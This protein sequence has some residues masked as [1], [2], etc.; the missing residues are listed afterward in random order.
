[1]IIL[2]IAFQDLSQMPF[3]QHDHV[4]QA[5]APDESDQPFH[6]GPVPWTGRSGENFLNAQALDSFAKVIP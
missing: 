5:V 1:V 3:S 2:K 6:V 4:I